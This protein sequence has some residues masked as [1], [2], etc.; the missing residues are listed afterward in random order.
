MVKNL[1]AKAGDVRDSSSIPGL[2]GSPGLETATHSSI[3]AWRLPMDRGAWGA[4]VHGVAK[5]QTGLSTHTHTEGLSFISVFFVILHKFSN[6]YLI[7]YLYLWILSFLQSIYLFTYLFAALGGVC[8]TW[9]VSLVAAYGLL[10]LRHVGSELPNQGWN[11][12]PL[13]RK[14]DS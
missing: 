3:L 5:S 2:G 9:G 1:P 14:T 13:L 4:T 12:Q 8:G 11:L 7:L 6:L 10:L